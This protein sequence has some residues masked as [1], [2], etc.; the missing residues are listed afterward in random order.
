MNKVG[1]GM[2]IFSPSLLSNI[3]NGLRRFQDGDLSEAY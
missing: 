1:Q 2:E 3:G